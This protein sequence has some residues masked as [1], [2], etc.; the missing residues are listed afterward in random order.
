MF[1]AAVGAVLSLSGCGPQDTMRAADSSSA[2]AASGTDRTADTTTAAAPT[3][4][5]TGSA[6]QAATAALTTLGTLPVK[7]RAP[8]T[9]Y[10]R[11]LFGQ[12]WSDDVNVEFGH[13][14]CDTRN[15]ILRRDLTGVVAKAGTRDCVVAAGTLDDAYTGKTIA[16]TRGESSSAAVQIDHLVA[17]SDAWQK[18]AQQ[19][20]SDERRD[21]ANDPRNLQAV[22]GPTNQAKGD[23]DTATWLP[24]NRRY[25]CTYVARQIEVKAAYRLWVTPAEKAAMTRVLTGCGGTA[26][27]D[28]NTSTT[29]PGETP[30]TPRPRPLVETPQAGGDVYYENCAAVR[31]AGKAPL[32]RGEPGYSAKLDRD[33]DGIACE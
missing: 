23:G 14:G 31:A 7:G 12:R 6:D 21:F 15:D 11:D 24:P 3:S 8:K 29:T 28:E 25:R 19:L 5:D 13:N 27:A 2:A 22:D 16:F 26:P 1:A 30:E 4:R 9:G 18:G 20:S 10:A 17:L 33:G 32:L